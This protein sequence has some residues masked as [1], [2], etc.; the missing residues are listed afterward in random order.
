MS[1]HEELAKSLHSGFIDTSIVSSEVYRP[2]LLVNDPSKGEKVLTNLISELKGCE[3]FYFSVAFIT[4]SG[5]AALLNTLH[6]LNQRNIAGKILASQYL[7]FTDPKALETLIQFGN[8]E[9][10]MATS[11]HLHSKGYIFNK[12]DT[13]TMIVG[14]SNLTQEALSTNKEWNIRISSTDQGSLLLHT[15]KEFEK[16][17]A[18]GTHVDIDWI[19]AY[20]KIYVRNFYSPIPPVKGIQPIAVQQNNVSYHIIPRIY[21]NKMQYKA[22]DGIE[23]LRSNKQK[24]ALL[25]SAT[26]T[27]KTYLAAFDVQRCKPR[28]MLFL[29]H[30]EQ[31]LNQ[32]I[33]SFKDILGHEI[34]VGK[35]VGGVKDHKAQYVF[36]TIQTMSKE[37]VYQG[38]PKDDFD[39]IVMDETHRAGATSYQKILNHF[40]P[41]FLLGMTAT[42]E[43]TDGYNIFEFFDYN[44]AY[45]IRLQDA[46]REDMLCPF[47]YYGVSEL[48]VNEQTIE[49]HTDFSRLT[50]TERIKHIVEKIKFYGYFGERVKGLVFCSRIEEAAVLA[51][52]F[53]RFGYRTTVLSGSDPQETRSA[54]LERLEQESYDGGLDYIF[55]VDLLNEGVDIPAVNQV[56]L[57]RPT[58]SPIVFVQQLG[59]GLRK[60]KDKD[61]LVVIDFIGNYKNNFMIPMAL[62]GDR[63]YNKD[64][65]RRYVLEGTRVVPGCST[66]QFDEI[67]RKRIFEAIDSAQLNT[68]QLL[69][70][71][72]QGLKYKV[73]RIPNLMDFET[74]GAID[75]TLFFSN[76][77]GSYQHFLIKHEPEYTSTFT[78]IQLEMLEYVSKKFAIGKR[79]HELMILDLMMMEK[80][81]VMKPFEESLLVNYLLP[82]DEQTKVSLV[83]NLTNEFIQGTGKDTYKRCIF[84]EQQGDGA[85]RISQ[86]YEEQL[87]DPAFKKAMEQIIEFGLYRNKEYYGDRYKKTSFQL[88][89]KYTYEDVCRLL[90]WEKSEVSLNIGG[91]K[92]DK[93]S[94]TFP[95][96]INYEKADEISDTIK[97]EDRLLSTD[98]LIAYSK[99]GRTLDSADIKTI[100]SAK[101]SGVTIFLF[102]RKNKDDKTAKEFYFL[103]EMAPHGK[104]VEKTMGSL[105]KSVVEIL[106]KLEDPIREDIYDYLIN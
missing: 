25:I 8:I 32:A 75:A 86:T 97:Y 29:V 20:K 85:F 1:I 98:E 69:K 43:R 105:Q 3:T 104:P 48:T 70:E 12:A 91:Y 47:H 53:Q 81:D 102:V 10:R 33:Q 34:S 18:L 51:S 72:Y 60:A 83:N 54:A 103:G 4:Q 79:V 19:N 65:I 39:Y 52:E 40:E 42:P 46:L 56:V 92:Y 73:G 21:P 11:G 62:G 89:Q 44:I 63:S 6:E 100:Y 37:S 87:N 7:N 61:Y 45:E 24:K 16:E 68:A 58:K 2:K 30:R 90:L 77:I 76:R 28:R 36:S 14:S 5:I 41:A 38:F 99:S 80:Q 57:L 66:I 31:I 82:F 67:S 95:V 78:D 9:L 74:F 15:I 26:G 88:Y 71:S 49:D 93:K 23:A 59:R 96:F 50:T 64:T 17:F 84:L 101:E 106:Y 35:Y 55:S 94:K 27:G 22:L 13:H